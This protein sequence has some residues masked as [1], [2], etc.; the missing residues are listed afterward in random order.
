MSG[1]VGGNL[2]F[3]KAAVELV[4]IGGPVWQYVETYCIIGCAL[5]TAG[6]GIYLL[7]AG[8]RDYDALY[9]VAVYQ[10]FLIVIGIASISPSTAMYQLLF[11]GSI[12]GV[13]FFKETAGMNALWQQCLY[14]ISIL[15]TINGIIML[16]IH[17]SS[18]EEHGDR[19][20]IALVQQNM[21]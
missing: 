7:N 20:S 14:P 9:L 18:R 2:F 21:V 8:L 5:G 4:H 17:R 15:I 16:S 11:L 6:G 10:S 19:E 12:S 1:L 13:V 3:L